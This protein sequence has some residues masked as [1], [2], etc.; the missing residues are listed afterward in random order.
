[1]ANDTNL[2]NVGPL[3]GQLSKKLSFLEKTQINAVRNTGSVSSEAGRIFGSS[4]K[5]ITNMSRSDV[6]AIEI[7][8]QIA[9][10]LE[11]AGVHNKT[12]RRLIDSSVVTTVNERTTLPVVFPDLPVD[13]SLSG[14]RVP[15]SNKETPNEII[16][17][18]K[19][20]IV[21][22]GDLQY[23]GLVYPQDLDS[24]APAYLR[25]KILK[26]KRP[27]AFSGGSVNQVFYIDLP[28]PENFSTTFSIKYQERD[29]GQLGQILQGAA[30]NRAAE[31]A[32]NAAGGAG[33]RLG[34]AVGSMV[35]SA[36]GA[37]KDGTYSSVLEVAERALFQELVSAE[38]T[39]GG[40]A[41][42]FAGAIPN[43]HPSVF[44]KGMDLRTFQWTWKFVPRSEAEVNQ[45]KSV[46]KFLKIHILPEKDNGFL[47]YPHMIEPEVQGDDTDFYSGFKKMMVRQF[48]IN[49]S[50]EGTSAYFVNG[51]PV[52][53]IVAMEM[54]E[55]EIF[56]SR[57]A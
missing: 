11:Q 36:T 47:K 1:M 51:A 12:T 18:S 25:L 48:S 20:S 54:Q 43:P 33:A 27:N 31:A 29:T 40:I 10:Q 15:T 22:V 21:G 23:G 4:S 28:L 2:K 16:K 57:D 8:S 30:G 17:K 39:V 26:Y 55:I 38:E 44:F 3:S 42:Q 41:E 6:S 46:L 19:E 34:A 5:A 49:Y 7:G 13:L 50:G 53:I 52:S 14:N 24:Q 37:V 35:E 32:S 56:S 9:V 45:L